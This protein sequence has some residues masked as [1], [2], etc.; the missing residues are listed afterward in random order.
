M[1]I[2]SLVFGVL[3]VLPIGSADMPVVIALLNAYAG[4]AAPQS[5]SPSPTTF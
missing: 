2:L 5:A 4:L 1:L 3:L